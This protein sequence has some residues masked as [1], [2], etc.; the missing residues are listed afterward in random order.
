[1]KYPFPITASQSDAAQISPLQ[2]VGREFFRFAAGLALTLSVLAVISPSV[3][4][5]HPWKR[6]YFIALW[7]LF[8]SLLQLWKARRNRH[9]GALA[10]NHA[11]RSAT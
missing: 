4:E 11:S 8:M 9:S 3:F 6:I 1:L 2:F 7:A 10:D 5:G